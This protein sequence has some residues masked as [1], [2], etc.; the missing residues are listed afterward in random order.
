MHLLAYLA[1]QREPVP[2]AT[3]AAALWPDELDSGAR[4]NLRRHLHHLRRA[5]PEIAE[6]DWL[7]DD[8]KLIGWNHA[9]PA[10]IDVAS[11]LVLSGDPATQADAVALVEGDLLA[12]FEDEW[13]VIERE[14][15]RTR[16]LDVLLDLAIARRQARDFPAAIAFGERL[17]A[18]DDLREDVVREIVT[19]RYEAGDRSGAVAAF[20][21]FAE[22]LKDTLGVEPSPETIALIAAVRAGAP[23]AVDDPG[24]AFQFQGWRPALAGRSAELE[25]LR[26][27]WQRAARG[28]GTTVFLSGEAGIGKSRL[29]A[30]LAAIVRNEGGRVIV[31]T[32]SDPEAEPYQALLVALRRVIPF[33]AGLSADDSTLMT[34]ARVLPE[35]RE[36]ADLPN[37]AEA[38]DIDAEATRLFDAF[39][40]FVERVAR[41]R[42]MLL[43]VEDLQWARAAT[44]DALAALARRA[45]SLP[46]MVLITYRSEETQT[47]HPLRAVR[48]KLS[49]EQRG[50]SVALRRL[51]AASV[52]RM[53]DWS[54][55][56]GA[57]EELAAAI[58][59]V[60]DGNPLFV[61]QLAR[62]YVETGVIPSDE[63]PLA[64]GEAIAE[65]VT[66]LDH[67][68]R[69]VGEVAAAIGETF[70]V[71]TVRDVGGWDEAWVLDALGDLMDAG[72]VRETGVEQYGYAFTHA[73]VTSA[74]YESAP[75]GKR[76]ARHRRIAQ[77]IERDAF[78]DR[79]SLER[80]ARHWRSAGDRPRAVAAYTRA[81][82]AALNVFAR[83]E[84]IAFARTACELADD[85]A[86]R[87]AAL[88]IAAA[89]PARSGDAEGWEADLTRLLALAQ[90]LGDAE[91]F[92]ALALRER[93]LW[94]LDRREEL[95]ETV[96]QMFALAERLG[97]AQRAIA[98]DA[99]GGAAQG[100]GSLRDAKESFSKALGL[101]RSLDDAQLVARLRHR[102][103]AM[104][105][106]LGEHEEA[107]NL[108][109]EQRAHLVQ[110][111]TLQQRLD[112]ARAEASL[113]VARLDD[114][115]ALRAGTEMLAIA[116]ETGDAD[117]ESKA[118]SLL[119]FAAHER[120]EFDTGRAHYVDALTACE[121]V[122]NVQLRANLLINHG[123]LET[124]AG[125]FDAALELWETALPLAEKIQWKT[126]IGYLLV[127]RS[128]IELIRGEAQKAA[129]T[130][131]QARAFGV[132]TAE[133]RLLAGALVAHGAALA[134]NGSLEDG[135]DTLQ[136]GIAERRAS[137]A[138]NGLPSDLAHLIEA[139]LAARR[140]AEAREPAAELH[141]LLTARPDRIAHPGRVAMALVHEAEARDDEKAAK[142]L[143]EVGRKL[144][145]ERVRLL[146]AQG[147]AYARLPFNAAL[148]ARV[149]APR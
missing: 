69:A 72:M 140:F 19:A 24:D 144:L 8:G 39:A 6:I 64:I 123:F 1:L 44:I 105:L 35:L 147:A 57:P 65:R 129:A 17:S 71:E 28:T 7:V 94:Q 103:I 77:L 45:G 133:R 66:R 149:A 2:R 146:G 84:A 62:A 106:R 53:L 42:P 67:R 116:R 25:T 126:G 78:E 117:A 127:G 79:A 111:A 110:G 4:A 109:E 70:S 10:S 9:A 107:S 52:R 85:A 145:A 121:K 23:L 16:Y 60:S 86:S 87:F 5:L 40:R 3:V 58:H 27:G 125:Q 96:A 139:L 138:T 136:Q 54:A 73:L 131:E 113:A 95:N 137:G 29:A 43:I 114:V 26:R 12:G 102:V 21:H 119:G 63:G 82:T 118:N 20:E 91:R 74:M 38:A 50:S 76:A 55:L 80:I 47:P 122:G 83:S 18:E 89:A 37:V 112:F 104:A 88:R 14:R 56:A 124:D 93:F 99:R 98:L 32:T 49:S 51:D 30:E 36:F 141:S 97:D 46:L 100:V 135:I 15:L 33:A 22:R 90:D 92:D 59:R 101:A 128:D 68:G 48:A 81:A 34:L 31:G 120:G 134:A 11:F 143:R 132:E 142:T 41:A 61:A 75:A 108:L 115:M 148:N 13:L 130:A